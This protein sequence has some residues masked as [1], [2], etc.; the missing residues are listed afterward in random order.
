[1]CPLNATAAAAAPLFLAYLQDLAFSSL[2][3][4]AG[5]F[6]NVLDITVLPAL[7]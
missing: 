5:Q 1:M 4:L 7:L 2:S 6:T 3:P